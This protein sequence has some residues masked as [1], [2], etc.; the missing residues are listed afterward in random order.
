LA[1]KLVQPEISV[2]V[3][4]YNSKVYYIITDGAGFGETVVRVPYTGN[5]T[6]LD[7]LSLSNWGGI[8]PQASKCRIWV[9]RPAPVD[10]ACKSGDQILKVDYNAIAQCGQTAT[11]WQ[12][13]PGDRVYIASDPLIK[14]DGVI[15]IITQPIERLFGFSLFGQSTI[16]RLGNKRAA[17]SSNG[18]LGGVGGIGT[19]TGTFGGV[20]F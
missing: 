9:A 11:N 12:L 16:L 14:L 8:A 3:L 20:G 2:D 15:S 13:F 17:S 1:D 10:V 5:E 18:I 4:G 6:V 19:G 7:A